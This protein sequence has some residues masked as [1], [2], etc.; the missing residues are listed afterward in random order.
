MISQ[1]ERESFY[2][3][4]CIDSEPDFTATQT[5]SL[6]SKQSR[7]HVHQTIVQI[8]RP[9]HQTTWRRCYPRSF[10]MLSRI[11]KRYRWQL[12]CPA[13]ASH[14]GHCHPPYILSSRRKRPHYHRH[15]RR[16]GDLGSSRRSYQTHA[17]GQLCR[18]GVWSHEDL[19]C[20][21]M[22]LCHNIWS[23]NCLAYSI[24]ASTACSAR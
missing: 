6:H 15:G 18:P 1:A 24:V 16:Q 7:G 2:D 21:T 23:L 14:F 8:A 11:Q 9:C 5:N 10:S 4:D 20:E 12:A 22:S 17:A 3:K 13:I 19:H